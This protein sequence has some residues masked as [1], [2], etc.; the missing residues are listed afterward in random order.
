M[1]LPKKLTSLIAAALA[2]AAYC[3]ESHATVLTIDDFQTATPFFSAGAGQSVS[4]SPISG[5]GILGTRTMTITVPNGTT[6]SGGSGSAGGGSAQIS[7]T[8]QYMTPVPGLTLDVMENFSSA[9]DVLGQGLTRLDFNIG[10]TLGVAVTI[11]ANGVSTY[12]LTDAANPPGIEHSIDLS[13]FSVPS[14]FSHLMSLDFTVTFPTG[15]SL[16][17]PSAGFNGPIFA[18]SPI[19]EPSSIVLSMVGVGA[20]L[21]GKFRVGKRSESA[22]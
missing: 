20:F 16:S 3:S 17:G 14:V 13:A 12:S 1:N 2:I 6:I 21:I 9:V 5:T 10:S 8:G 4:S 7:F 11:T 19:P 15:N 22:V 18:A